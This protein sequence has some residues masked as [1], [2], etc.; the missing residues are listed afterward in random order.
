MKLFIKKTQYGFSHR[1]K[2]DYQGN[3]TSMY[4]DIQFM[5]DAEPEADVLQ[6]DVKD[7]FFSC[8]DSSTGVKPKLVIKDYEVIK[9]FENNQ[10]SEETTSNT[11]LDDF[12]LD[13][14]IEISDDAL[15]F[16]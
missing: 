13:V 15:P 7:A 12:D 6:I 8:Y 1:I 3:E 10:T 2:N 4:L 11:N 5:K 14:D 9:T 16:D